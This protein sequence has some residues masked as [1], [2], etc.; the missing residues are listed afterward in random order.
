MN[1]R[2]DFEIYTNKIRRPGQEIKI[3]RPFI[4]VLLVIAAWARK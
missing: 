4:F 1:V 3:P 2:V